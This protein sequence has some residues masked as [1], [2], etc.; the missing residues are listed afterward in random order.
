ME[1]SGLVAHQET[2][3]KFEITVISLVEIAKRLVHKV[4]FLKEVAEVVASD[5]KRLDCQSCVN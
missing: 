2:S 1:S 3:Q 5:L 4:D